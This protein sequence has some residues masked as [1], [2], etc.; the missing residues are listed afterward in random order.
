MGSHFFIKIALITLLAILCQFPAYADHLDQD[1]V[2]ADL[3]VAKLFDNNCAVCHGQD[4]R[5]VVKLPN[6]PDFSRNDF[7]DSRPESL[8]VSSIANGRNSMPAFGTVLTQNQ[9]KGL[10]RFVRHFRKSSR[11]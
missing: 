7:Q 9:I 3:A 6:L 4:G 11:A 5:G 1:G 8:L 2:S 10:V